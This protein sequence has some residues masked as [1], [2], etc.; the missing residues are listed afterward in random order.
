M[1]IDNATLLPVSNTPYKYNTSRKNDSP[2]LI[3]KVTVTK[4][5]FAHKVLL[6]QWVYTSAETQN[7]MFYNEIIDSPTLTF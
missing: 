6:V 5:P 4:I 3:P 7:K 1:L 2:T